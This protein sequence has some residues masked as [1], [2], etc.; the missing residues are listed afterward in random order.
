MSINT[1]LLELG[2][3]NVYIDEDGD[4]V[5]EL[6][7]GAMGDELAITM[8]TEAVALTAAQTGTVPQAKVVTGGSFRVTIPFKEIKKENFSRAFPNANFVEGGG[9]SRVDFVP[10]VGLNLRTIAKKMKIV[11]VF[12]LVESTDPDDIFTIPLA[13]PADTEVVVPFSPT[14]QR[15]ITATFEAWP[16][17][18]AD[19]PHGFVQN[20]WAFLGDEFTT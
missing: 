17:V 8:A 13:S 9:G 16:Q 5:A 7:L 4:G 19:P 1:N 6:F 18:E 20:R 14:E 15:V 12:G 2:P 10:Q 3:A 11:K